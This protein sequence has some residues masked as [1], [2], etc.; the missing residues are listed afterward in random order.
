MATNADQRKWRQIRISAVFSRGEWLPI[1]SPAGV[2]GRFIV[3][4]LRNRMER[5]ETPARE[6]KS[7][8]A[9]EK[10]A[11]YGE[12]SCPLIVIVLSRPSARP[13]TSSVPSAAQGP[14]SG[15][16]S[17]SGQVPGPR[18]ESWWRSLQ[19]K[20]RGQRAGWRRRSQ[21]GKEGRRAR[22]GGG[23]GLRG[24]GSCPW[25]RGSGGSRRKDRSESVTCFS[26]AK[27]S[28]IS[29]GCCCPSVGHL[30]VESSPV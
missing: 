25:G 10:L 6:A 7:S 13:A 30:L 24:H 4:T 3:S 29:L 9:S 19:E 17:A 14:G 23:A 5:P 28:V 27:H 8:T 12:S 16:T 15:P 20:K 11:L 22:G 2:S 26:W 18:P 21:E 1:A